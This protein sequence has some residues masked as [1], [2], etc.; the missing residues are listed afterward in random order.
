MTTKEAPRNR[1]R[2]I[3]RDD[4]SE[5]LESL[6]PAERSARYGNN[7]LYKT[8]RSFNE[9]ERKAALDTCRPRKS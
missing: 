9:A 6:K 7:K 3:V 5:Y 2:F 1:A 4:A 8:G